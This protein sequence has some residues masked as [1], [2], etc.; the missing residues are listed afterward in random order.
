MLYP[1]FPPVALIF[2]HASAE[3]LFQL[4]DLFVAEQVF[5]GGLRGPRLRFSTFGFKSASLPPL[6]NFPMRAWRS[7]WRASRSISLKSFPSLLLHDQLAIPCGGGELHLVK[8][9]IA[10]PLVALFPAV[11]G[12]FLAQHF[13]NAGYA[14]SLKIQQ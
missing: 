7:D 10:A 13:S 5:S 6:L 4:F 8:R 14:V 9:A 1:C 3:N 2:E 12:C 11:N